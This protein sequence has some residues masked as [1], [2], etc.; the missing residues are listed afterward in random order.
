MT[1]REVWINAFCA[2]LE[3][4]AVIGPERLAIDGKP[5]QIDVFCRLMADK[6]VEYCPKEDK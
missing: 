6:A 2:A 4:V 3:A 5:T 1:D